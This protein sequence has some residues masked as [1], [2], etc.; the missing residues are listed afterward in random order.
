MIRLTLAV[1]LFTVQAMA[2]G[3]LTD[4]YGRTISI[5][6][7]V[8]STTGIT[9]V[10][11]SNAAALVTFNAMSP[12]DAIAAVTSTIPVWDF[13]NRF[14][15]AEFNALE[16]NAVA[17]GIIAKMNAWGQKGGGIT[18]TDP[19]ITGYMAQAVSAGLI[20]APRSAQILNLNVSS[21]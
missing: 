2:Q 5:N 16:A 10:A 6:G 12:T 20:T 21:P 4:V 14:T 1:L 13:F 11:S 8:Y 3:T 7:H 15:Q 9:I 17:A 18:V 19:T